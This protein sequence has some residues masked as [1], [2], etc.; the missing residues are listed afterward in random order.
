MFQM[1][2][3]NKIKKEYL[4]NIVMI[5]LLCLFLYIPIISKAIVVK[6]TND[7]YVNDYANILSETVERFIQNTSVNLERKTGVQVVVVTVSSLEGK[8]IEEYANELFNKWGIGDHKKDNGLL[9]L[10]S[11]DDRKFRI[12]VGYGLEGV[13]PDGKTGRIQDEYIIPYL[14][15]NNFNKGILEGYKACVS[16]VATEYDIEIDEIDKNEYN[17]Q[18]E[19]KKN[20]F[21]IMD[22]LYI[23]FI[24]FI[25][26]FSF[27]HRWTIY[28]LW[29]R[30]F[31][32]WLFFFRWWL[33]WRRRKLWR[34]R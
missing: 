5:I 28:F 11:L 4:K 7:F 17:R 31:R 3:S 9:L 32:W 25:I 34:R 13:L 1:F 14:R 26:Y 6:P 8:S 20:G 21:V 2:N 33:F 16:S 22:F 18:I 24:C 12:E 27:K 30:F 10:C 29:R 15:N 19:Q 23:L